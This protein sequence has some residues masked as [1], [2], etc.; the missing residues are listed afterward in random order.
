AGGRDSPLP[1]LTAYDVL[2]AFSAA[3]PARDQVTIDVE[4]IDVRAG[5]ILV[6]GQSA[7]TGETEA[8][9]VL[10]LVTTHLKKHRGFKDLTDES[11]P[12]PDGTRT[13]T[14]NIKTE[15]L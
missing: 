11:Q 2:L 12:G 6:R 1:E 3:L 9:D 14:L 10:K 13:F 7:R 4:E 8:Q 15:C 5:K